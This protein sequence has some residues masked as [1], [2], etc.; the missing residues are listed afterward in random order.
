MS[1]D[2]G[3]SKH[4]GSW[5][6]ISGVCGRSNN[7]GLSI[8]TKSNNGSSTSGSPSSKK[9]LTC[10][11][12]LLGL[13][14]KT[15]ISSISSIPQDHCTPH[16]LIDSGEYSPWIIQSKRFRLHVNSLAFNII[17]QYLWC[18]VSLITQGMYVLWA[19]FTLSCSS[20]EVSFHSRLSVTHPITKMMEKREMN[21]LYTCGIMC[22]VCLPWVI[23][24]S[25]W[26]KHIQVRK[27]GVI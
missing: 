17:S 4:T 20:Y 19:W 27:T 1:G 23:S 5:S 3:L 18:S 9:S 7:I 12:V 21:D 11:P 6:T 2:P 14:Q 16:Y 24:N 13:V 22:L 15:S 26:R 10:S 8:S 25:H